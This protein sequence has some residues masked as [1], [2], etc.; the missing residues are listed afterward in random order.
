MKRSNWQ[1]FDQSMQDAD[2]DLSC[3]AC[4]GAGIVEAEACSVTIRQN[5]GG[6][7]YVERRGGPATAV[8]LC[9]ACWADP[10]LPNT[11]LVR[12]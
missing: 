3:P 6:H 1:E 7:F 5:V 2:P 9:I 8:M 11:R 12:R 4:N 10:T